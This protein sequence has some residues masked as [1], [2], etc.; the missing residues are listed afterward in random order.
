MA[1]ADIIDHYDRSAASFHRWWLPVIE[2]AA[3]HLL[4][5]IDPLVFARPAAVI[6]DVGAGTGPL[7]RA[8]VVRWPKVRVVG[9]DPSEGMLAMGRAA[10][11]ASL[12]PP[13]RRRLTWVTGV[14]ERLPIA[15]GSADAVVSSFTLQ[16]LRRRGYA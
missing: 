7:G 9:V 10:A 8:A 4:D 15:T 16:Y 14:A 13:A 2:P 12:D 6:V 11:D 5:L 3:L 1:L